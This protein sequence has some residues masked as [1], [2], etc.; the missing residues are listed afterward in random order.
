MSD[1]AA[2]NKLFFSQ[3]LSPCGQL[4]RNADPDLFFCIVCA[5]Q[6]KR[7]ECFVLV[8][9]YHEMLKATYIRHSYE[10]NGAMAGFI[11]LQWWYETL[12]GQGEYHEVAK[13]LLEMLAMEKVHRSSLLAMIE[14]VEQELQGVNSWDDWQNTLQASA[15]LLHALLAEILGVKEKSALEQA[16]HAGT[17]FEMA[18]QRRFLFS[19][20]KAGRFFLPEVFLQEW[21]SDRVKATEK[22]IPEEMATAYE[23]IVKKR[24][25]DLLKKQPSYALSRK[26]IMPWLPLALARRDLNR[27]M[28][29]PGHPLGHQR[30]KR[31]GGWQKRRNVGDWLAVLAAYVSKNP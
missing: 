31:S 14:A 10:R 29:P 13:P 17:I 25:L 3:N 5:P 1:N 22:G 16:S 24:A 18:R 28:N 7:E 4:V 8:A 27:S 26:E 9:F 11:R 2:K 21:H 20:L 15:G 30:G 19:L 12:E 6:E 23:M